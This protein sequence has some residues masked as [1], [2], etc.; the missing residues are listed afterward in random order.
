MFEFKKIWNPPG[1][2]EKVSISFSF[3]V[4]CR[5]HSFMQIRKKAKMIT[6]KDIYS[7]N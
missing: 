3:Y 2:Q 5:R 4:F 6:K 1:N 7:A